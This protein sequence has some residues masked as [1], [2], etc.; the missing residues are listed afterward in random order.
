MLKDEEMFAF[1]P[2]I[3]PE[4]YIIKII[5]AVNSLLSTENWFNKL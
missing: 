5:L 4:N 3:V 2:H 1:H